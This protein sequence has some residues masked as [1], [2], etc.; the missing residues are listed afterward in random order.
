M[1]LSFVIAILI[2]GAL[3]FCANAQVPP[4]TSP[5]VGTW[6][7]TNTQNNCVD[8]HTFNADGTYSSTSGAEVL[9]GT[10]TITP[11]TDPQ[12]RFKVVRTIHHDNG[13]KD[14]D[15]GSEDDGGKVDTRYIMFH[16]EEHQM[17]VCFEPTSDEC[18][19]PLTR[20]K[21]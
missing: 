8:S 20:V 3:S 2:A 9:Q 4:G 13:G 15:G 1:K 21:R 14:C 11:P 5:I 12:G 17:A 18:F 19:G 7:I 6:T 16:P 10:Y